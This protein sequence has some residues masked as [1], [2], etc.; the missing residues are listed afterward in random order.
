MPFFNEIFVFLYFHA[1][2]RCSNMSHHLFPR[3]SQTFAYLLDAKHPPL[4]GGDADECIITEHTIA[5]FHLYACSSFD[6]GIGRKL[7]KAGT[8]KGHVKIL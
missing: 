7:A 8:Y 5:L 3:D 1:F 2:V 6:A 4:K